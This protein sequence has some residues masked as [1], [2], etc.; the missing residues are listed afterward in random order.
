MWRRFPLGL[1]T[2]SVAAGVPFR[3]FL[4]VIFCG[5]CPA[6]LWVSCLFCISAH[7]ILQVVLRVSV[8][9]TC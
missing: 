9:S 4:G 8:Q 1:G 7:V 6:G 3:R 5:F 2:R